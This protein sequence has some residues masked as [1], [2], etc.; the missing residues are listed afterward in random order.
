[1]GPRGETSLAW[2]ARSESDDLDDCRSPG[3][4][5]SILLEESRMSKHLGASAPEVEPDLRRSQAF[6]VVVPRWAFLGTVATTILMTVLFVLMRALA[7]P[8]T[9][10]D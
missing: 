4:D 2:D 6:V 10:D 7:P 5:A 9:L 8:R 1:M 3:L